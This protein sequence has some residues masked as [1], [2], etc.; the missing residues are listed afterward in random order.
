MRDVA[1]NVTGVIPRS[2]ANGP[3]WRAVV[4]VQG[5]TVGCPG[6]FNPQTHQHAQRRLMDPNRLGEDLLKLPGLEGLTISGG[7]PFE[8]AEGCAR[9][10]R[11][12]RAEGWSVMAFTGYTLEALRMSSKQPVA[13]F[14]GEIDLLIA[15]PYV[16]SLASN[17]VPWAG[18]SNKRLHYLTYRYGA[19]IEQVVRPDVEGVT[20]GKTLTWTG[21]PRGSD[22]EWMERM[23]L[24]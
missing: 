12:V 8:Q 17:V 19:E 4:W 21:F 10:A 1:L 6:C 7:E 5:C 16:A 18:S 13:D 24:I 11:R 22:R 20:D 15:G 2:A 23:P 9:L 3:G 14:L